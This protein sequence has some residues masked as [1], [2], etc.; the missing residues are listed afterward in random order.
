MPDKTGY[1][2]FIEELK[3]LYAQYWPEDAGA[4]YGATEVESLCL[5]FNITSP[6]AVIRAYRKYR[7]PG[8]Y[9]A[10]CWLHPQALQGLPP[11]TM[12]A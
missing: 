6:R 10:A 4:L 7:D 3:V 2:K 12:Q 11:L 5:R 9:V 1:N 8:R